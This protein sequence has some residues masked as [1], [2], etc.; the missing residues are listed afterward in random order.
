MEYLEMKDRRARLMKNT[1]G[2]GKKAKRS[3]IKDIIKKQK[4]ELC[5]IQ[6]TKMGEVSK[7]KCT[8]LWG[9]SYFD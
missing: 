6:E 3:E 4:I 1:R 8:G 5:C 9:D 7:N 2:L